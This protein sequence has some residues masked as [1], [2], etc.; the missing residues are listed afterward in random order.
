[1]PL[2]A[3]IRNVVAFHMIIMLNLFNRRVS[4]FNFRLV[5]I[6]RRRRPERF[7]CNLDSGIDI[8]KFGLDFLHKILLTKLIKKNLTITNLTI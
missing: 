8:D 1:M 4:F 5:F 6:I 7:L 2:C 3:I